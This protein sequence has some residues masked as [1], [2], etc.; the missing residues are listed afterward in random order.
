M[1]FPSTYFFGQL[2]NGMLGD[3][4]KA[5]YLICSG[6][7]M[8]GVSIILFLRLLATPMLARITYGF[9]GF[10]LSMIFAPLTRMVALITDVI[11]TTVVFWMPVYI[12]ENLGF[13]ADRA[14]SVFAAASLPDI[15]KAPMVVHIDFC[16]GK[17]KELARRT[18]LDYF[19]AL[20]LAL[21][22]TGVT[23]CIENFF[24]YISGEKSWA[25][26]FYSD[27][28]DICDVIDT[29]NEMHGLHFAACLDTGHAVVAKNDPVEMLRV[30]GRRTKVLHI[31][32][33]LGVKDNHLIPT[34]GTIDWKKVA[35]ALGEIGYE[36]T[37][38]FEMSKPLSLLTKD[39]FSR[40]TFQNACNYLY[41]IG[42][43]LADIAEGTFI[44]G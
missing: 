30:L 16:D 33:N 15:W 14:S 37:F 8:A 31:Q 3:K 10:F 13:G 35:T 4:I 20:V 23:M 11:R 32:D 7:I 17:S 12:S 34:E 40:T 36:G 25:S 42:R 18:T 41:S 2:I 38:N 22:E 5:R 21:K 28:E 24:F 19:S 44:P 9:T 26:N 6:V 27:A 39:T 1:H 29:L 43:S